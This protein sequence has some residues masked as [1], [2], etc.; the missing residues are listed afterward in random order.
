MWQPV[1]ISL[2]YDEDHPALAFAL[3]E[4]GSGWNVSLVGT[5]FNFVGAVSSNA[6]NVY[7]YQLL[8]GRSRRVHGILGFTDRVWN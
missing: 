3:V 5:S 2:L 4:D 8:L 6:E 7:K 1:D